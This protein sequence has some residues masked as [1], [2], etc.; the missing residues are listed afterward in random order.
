MKYGDPVPSSNPNFP[1]Y[2]QADTQWQFIVPTSSEHKEIVWEFL[3]HYLKKDQFA[4]R[5]PYDGEVPSLKVAA[6]EFED[7][8]VLDAYVWSAEYA[9][10]SGY[11]VDREKWNTTMNT[12]LELLAR[13][14][15]T[16]EDALTGMCED[17]DLVLAG[18]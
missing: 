4:K 15:L 17:L 12:Y 14:E 8:P 3:K 2:V 18:Q 16:P 7:D 5:V 10:W 13:G 11:K 6:L 9:L 1:P